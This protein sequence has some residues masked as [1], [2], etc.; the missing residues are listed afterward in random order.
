MIFVKTN[1]KDILNKEKHEQKNR[2]MAIWKAFRLYKIST[3]I[4][5]E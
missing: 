3:L 5:L 2:K 1:L 4:R